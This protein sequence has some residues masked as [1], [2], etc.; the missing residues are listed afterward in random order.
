MN[1]NDFT[2]DARVTSV[3]IIA[4][5]QKVIDLNYNFVEH[6][7]NECGTECL[8]VQLDKKNLD[9]ELLEELLYSESI[10]L[11]VTLDLEK[12]IFIRAHLNK[13]RNHFSTVRLNFLFMNKFHRATFSS[14]KNSIL[15]T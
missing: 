7:V 2:E 9:L 11:I 14:R 15:T 8:S 5:E 13:I 3:S 1:T 10:F 12:E 4:A 6:S